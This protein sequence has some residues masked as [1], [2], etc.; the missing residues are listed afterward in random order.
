MSST[1]RRD[2]PFI[3]L[4]LSG[5]ALLQDI[6]R[7]VADWH[8]SPED[9]YAARMELHDFL[10][11]S[12]NEYRLWVEKPES[13]RFTLMSRRRGIPLEDILESNN[14]NLQVAARSTNSKNA[15]EV[16]D[17]L[18]SVGRIGKPSAEA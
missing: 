5:R 15:Q 10:G 6:D 9:S 12:W 14:P 17:W 18:V 13:L 4:V 11:L 3:E 1:A 8:E 2:T 7:F 16:Y